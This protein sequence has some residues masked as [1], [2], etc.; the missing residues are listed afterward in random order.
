MPGNVIWSATYDVASRKLAEKLTQNASVTRA[1]SYTYNLT[2]NGAGQLATFTDP[3]GIVS[4]VS[5]DAQGR[6]IQVVAL[7][8]STAQAGVTRTFGYDRR[9]LLRQIDQTYQNPALS[10]S[11]SVKRT[12]DGYG[13]LLTEQTYIA[14]L[15]KDTWQQTRDSAGRRILLTELNNP[16]LPFIYKYQADGNLIEADFNNGAYF[17]EYK[18]DG[19]LYSR[20]TPLHAQVLGR[21]WSGRIVEASEYVGATLVLNEKI[22]W[23]A[24]ST[25]SANAI[26]RI[27]GSTWSESR[28]YNY[29]LR[30]R[31]ISES[32]AAR[33]GVTGSAGYQFD[34]GAP[35]GIGVRTGV[36]L[37]GNLSG[38][39]TGT[40]NAFAQ[41]SSLAASGNLSGALANPV[42]QTFDSAGNVT[43]RLR[44]GGSDT[45]SWD[46]L[47]RLVGLVRRDGSNSGLNW[48]A[49]YDGLGRRLQTTQQTVTGGALSGSALTL[50]SA[51]DPE[52]EFLE[53]SATVGATR[54]WLIHGPDLNGVYGGLQGTGGLEAVY[55][56]STGLTTGIVSD[57]SGHVAAT[58]TS[59]GIF[60]WNPVASTGYGTAAGSVPA[61]PLDASRDFASILGWRGHYLDCTGFYAMGMRYYDPESGTFLS[62]DP[63]GHP[64]SLSLYDY[65]ASDP[66][67]RVDPD[68]RVAKVASQSVRV[69]GEDADQLTQSMVEGIGILR[70]IVVGS[71][72]QRNT[73][74]QN[75]IRNSMAQQIVNFEARRD[76]QGFI[77]VYKLPFNDG[78]GAYEVAGINDRYHPE[79]ASELRNMIQS[80]HPIDAEKLAVNY[81]QG[82]TNRAETWTTQLGVE[83][84]LRDTIFNRGAGGAV[85]VLQIALGLSVDGGMGPITRRAV[86]EAEN[87]PIE[88]LDKLRRAREKYENLVAPGRQNLRPG[89]INRW[90]NALEFSK[91]I[92]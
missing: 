84:Y 24:D 33:A 50:K 69:T 10:P 68:G 11:T 76:R 7:D 34:G 73:A 35:G 4:S 1:S 54:N 57:N 61:P 66:I 43:T 82:Y 38:I 65:C 77:Q 46:A 91:K 53:V 78:G 59:N 37:A 29:D 70:V 3:R 83:S 44:A 40:Y 17:Y 22:A 90:D 41:L 75:I 58:I 80:G 56:A 5:Y 51:F 86:T 12:Y 13:A 74:S 87:N 71:G 63:L 21:D 92:M 89:L 88:F 49:V 15:L 48:S 6:Q 64:A 18:I 60:A 26:T 2:G 8:A 16:A 30:G 52:V 39:Q 47:G 14:G 28:S 31:L 81:I 72:V 36:T 67:N 55:N 62:A 42:T 25:Q 19:R 45:L 85:K 23:R 20:N 9:N 27:G 32:F 79:V